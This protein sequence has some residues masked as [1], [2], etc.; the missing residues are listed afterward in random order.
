MEVYDA[1]CGLKDV[2]AGQIAR[3]AGTY[4]LTA[5]RVLRSSLLC[6]AL[7]DV[8]KLTGNFQAMM[9]AAGDAAYKEAV[10]ANYRHEVAPLWLIQEAARDLVKQAGPI[11]GDGR[12]EVLAVAGHH[13][14]L[15]DDYLFDEERFLQPLTWEPDAWSAVTAA[16]GLAK[17]MFRAQGWAFP[18]KALSRERLEE[19]LVNER[20]EEQLA[21][22]PAAE[23]SPPFEVLRRTRSDLLGAGPGGRF[24][25]LFVLLKGLLMTAD[26]MASGAQGK[27]EALDAFK[28]VVRVPPNALEAHL[29]ER[30]ERRRTE[31]PD[32]G[33]EPFREYSRFQAACAAADGHV[34]AVA[35]TGRGKTEAS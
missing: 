13:R 23:K 5:E 11:P 9:R 19:Q 17:A 18:V 31:R 10:K 12:L 20:L 32:L 3:V 24:R 2:H 35:P 16:C 30:V 21:N 1:W 4:G 33:L 27:P 7:H 28:G 34:I 6:V 14:Y 22:D 26:W 25:E 8:G 29:R 15:A